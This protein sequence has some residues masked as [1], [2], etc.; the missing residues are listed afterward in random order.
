[1]CLSARKKI[2][3]SARKKMVTE[4]GLNWHELTKS[5]EKLRSGRADKKEGPAR[6]VQLTIQLAVQEKSPQWPP[7]GPFKRWHLFFRRRRP[8][9]RG[10]TVGIRIRLRKFII[11]AATSVLPP[12]FAIPTDCIDKELTLNS[13]PFLGVLEALFKNS[14]EIELPFFQICRVAHR[15]RKRHE[16][17]PSKLFANAFKSMKS[18]IFFSERFPIIEKSGNTCEYMR[19][20]HLLRVQEEFCEEKTFDFKERKGSARKLVNHQCNS[21]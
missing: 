21:V 9:E 19:S 14:N 20:R 8:S 17:G 18:E 5:D 15:C 4:V 10:H 7:K 13:K 12:S 3:K 6:Y 2:E 16:I 1:M 11:A